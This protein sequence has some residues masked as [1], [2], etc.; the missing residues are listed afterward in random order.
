V[1]TIPNKISWPYF[2]SDLLFN[3]WYWV[4]GQQCQDHR[5]SLGFPAAWFA[6]HTYF[7]YLFHSWS[8]KFQPPRVGEMGEEQTKYRRFLL[9]FSRQQPSSLLD[10]PFHLLYWDELPEAFFA[11]RVLLGK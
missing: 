1:Q 9:W 5:S 8:E 4:P 2:I 7:F 3:I 11:V 10:F 6:M